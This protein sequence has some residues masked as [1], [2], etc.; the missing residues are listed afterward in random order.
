MQSQ[1]WQNDLCLILRQTIQYHSN[2]N[3]CPNPKCQRSWSWTVLRR[4]IRPSR[5]N[6]KKEILFI[7]GNWNAKVGNQEITGVTDKFGLGIKNEERQRLTEFCQQNG[8]VTASTLFQQHKR[9]LYAWKSSDGQYWNQIDYILCNRRWRSST[10]SAKTTLGAD[11]GSYHELLM[12]KF[13]LKLKR[14]GKTT[15]LLKYDLN[16]SLMIIQWKWQIDSR[17]KTW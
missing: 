14:V 15:R 11:C 5:T 17:D 12:G 9:Q 3:L 2:P 13:R 16:E 10:Q 1:K 7:I 6:S 4:P 8:L